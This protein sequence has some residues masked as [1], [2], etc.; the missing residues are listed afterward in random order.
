MRSP[1]LAITVA[2]VL[3]I[4]SQHCH[5]GPMP[6][7]P[8]GYTVELA[9]GYPL[10]DHPMMGCFDD[11]GRLYV[12]ES[13][14]TNRPAAELLA[15]PLDS[16]RV[17]EDTD[18]DGVFD[19]S[20]TFADKLVFPQGCLW[21]DG[22]L[23][24]CSPPSLWKLDDTDG[25]GVCDQR[26]ELVNSFGFNGN[27]ADIHGPFLS[28]EGRLFWCDGRHGHEFFDAEGNLVSEGKAARTACRT[29]AMCACCAAA[30]WTTR[31][32]STSGR[33]AKSSAPAICSMPIRAATVW[34]T[35]CMAASIRESIS[36]TASPSSPGRA[37]C[38]TRFTT[39]ATSR[40][41]E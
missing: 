20:W 1:S 4:A 7:V 33:R 22:S 14:G 34:C 19:N 27:A 15:D 38:S 36:R 31:S 39:T 40:W 8:E 21:L 24:T 30:E 28:P 37:A 41:R 26:T 16:I 25:D 9:A 18:G 17:L 23:Y 10:V 2:A 6:T 3:G 11:Q 32:R 29:A 5:A 12:C 13:A 35:G